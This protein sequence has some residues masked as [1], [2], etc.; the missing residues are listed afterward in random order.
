MDQVSE[1]VAWTQAADP[2]ALATF[3]VPAVLVALT[4]AYVLQIYLLDPVAIRRRQNA[5]RGQA[6]LDNLRKKHR[7]QPPPVVEEKVSS[8][9]KVSSPSKIIRGNVD[10]S[11]QREEVRKLT[12]SYVNK[13]EVEHIAEQA[14]VTYAELQKKLTNNTELLASLQCLPIKTVDDLLAYTASR[15]AAASIP[16]P[17]AAGVDVR[18][19]YAANKHSQ[20]LLV[21]HDMKGGYREDRYVQGLFT[22]PSSHPRLPEDGKDDLQQVLDS[23]ST[24]YEE[25]IYRLYHWDSI[26]IFVYFAHELVVIPPPAWTNVAHL[27]DTVMLGT[28]ITEWAEGKLVCERLFSSAASAQQAAKAL[29]KV[30]V[31]HGFDGWLINIENELAT[32]NIPHMITFLATLTHAMRKAAGPR[33]RVIWYDAVTT[34]GKLQWQDC[35]SPLNQ[36]FVEACDGL[37]T[38]Y[39]WK[40]G[41]PELCAA[42]AQAL[43]SHG[44]KEDVFMGVDVFGRGSFGGG[45]DNCGEAVRA[46]R[47]AGVSAAI[48]AP[49]WVLEDGG[50]KDFDKRQR[51]WWSD[52]LNAWSGIGG[53]GAGTPPC[54]PAVWSYKDGVGAAA[55]ATAAAKTAE[56][57]KDARNN[58]SSS[59][60][61]GGWTLVTNFCQGTGQRFCREG[62]IL[63]EG[64]WADLSEQTVQS[65]N[66]IGA[67]A[68]A[69][70]YI[71]DA[72]PTPSSTD[73]EVVQKKRNEA[74]Q[75]WLFEHTFERSAKNGLAAND[76]AVEAVAAV[77]KLQLQQQQQQQQQQ[78]EEEEAPS[79]LAPAPAALSPAPAP[80]HPPASAGGVN[81]FAQQ[82][83]LLQAAEDLGVRLLGNGTSAPI[84]EALRNKVVGLYFSAHWCPPCRSFTPHLQQCYELLK[85]MGR[86]FEIVFVSRDHTPEEFAEYFS[87]MPWLALPFEP[88]NIRAT[89]SRGFAVSGIP[90]LVLLGANGSTLTTEGR[91]WFT[92][93]PQPSMAVAGVDALI[94]WPNE[95]PGQGGLTPAAIAAVGAARK[96]Q[97]QP[98]APAP[99]PAPAPVGRP[100]DC[101]VRAQL[102]HDATAFNGGSSILLQGLLVRGLPLRL[103]LFGM[104]SSSPSL[105]S[106]SSSSKSSALP[107]ASTTSSGT[108]HVSSSWPVHFGQALEVSYCCRLDPLT[109]SEVCLE[110]RLSANQGSGGARGGDSTVLVL[111]GAGTDA[112]R[113]G[114]GDGDGDANAGAGPGA[115]AGAAG[116]EL[117]WSEMVDKQGGQGQFSYLPVSTT[118][119]SP[120]AD[121]SK[122]GKG[123]GKG[124]AE[125]GAGG[126]ESGAR[127]LSQVRELR[128]NGVPYHELASR[129]Q[130][131]PKA[132]NDPSSGGGLWI[133]R[134]YRLRGRR[135][136]FSRL[137]AVNVVCVLSRQAP[138]GSV[139]A[140]RAHL[141]EVAITAG[142]VSTSRTADAPALSGLRP[143]PPAVPISLP[144]PCTNIQLEAAAVSRDGSTP[145]VS[146]QISWGFGD[147]AG[148]GLLRPFSLLAAGVGFVDVFDVSML[149]EGGA[150][151]EGAVWV[152]RTRTPQFLLNQWPIAKGASKLV[153]AFEA[154]GISSLRRNGGVR[155]APAISIA[156]S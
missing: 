67:A 68:R 121:D 107:N 135:V 73:A 60:Q 28:F 142:P 101:V 95:V 64:Q 100:V 85:G 86:P 103:P 109:F 83:P 127:M 108:V 80:T 151:D 63:R 26:D 156:L 65:C 143:L 152:G 79:S 91:Q 132:G 99:A 84:G 59:A 106:A 96:Q 75:Q 72:K 124:A 46:A 69:T 88:A 133:R 113:D 52:V 105:S 128:A 119:F 9:G 54:S 136:E 137:T 148:E 48:F 87:T 74:A 35:L 37:F 42:R 4:F 92:Q 38:N 22:T 154:V 130:S 89:L 14:T 29:V 138:K 8:P 21:C 43:G 155:K 90:A 146:A 98:A 1:L 112:A 47:M 120:S 30:A 17:R 115:G 24:N 56:A 149:N 20:Q 125:T 144:P 122:K 139:H 123:D 147:G 49:G 116:A 78:Q 134:K 102:T 126:G 70:K 36:P 13:K 62:A 51:R 153:L 55:A 45:K 131:K 114:G 140:Y 33:S 31:N 27:H 104:P 16:L 7:D 39:T 15:G 11:A 94:N 5:N 117:V 93:Y 3:Y 97:Q 19:A 81:L 44:R 32:E 66:I 58:A 12:E 129:L 41:A 57:N 18:S 110:L 141:G 77:K 53:V 61:Q 25:E 34:E 145:T 82:H 23:G 150:G 111:K 50:G 10:L 118:I 6:A 71:R 76:A 2:L 40:K